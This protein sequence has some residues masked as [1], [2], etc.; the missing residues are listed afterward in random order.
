MNGD[1]I[2]EILKID[3]AVLEHFWMTLCWVMLSNTIYITT[4]ITNYYIKFFGDIDLTPTTELKD[5]ANI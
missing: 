1:D 5:I 2:R 4:T 3:Q